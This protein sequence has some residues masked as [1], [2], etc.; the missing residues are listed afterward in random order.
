MIQGGDPL[1]TGKGGV[2]IWGHTFPDEFNKS[3]RFE[4]GGILAMAN[5]G[6]N[7]NTSQFFIT[8]KSAPNLNDKHTIF[9]SISGGKDVLKKLETLETDDNEKPIENVYIIQTIVYYNPFSSEQ[10]EDEKQEKK[11]QEKIENDKQ[12]FG[13]WLSNP[14]PQPIQGGGIGKY[15]NITT[16]KKTTKENLPLVK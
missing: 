15:L 14:S 8:Y 10:I 12:L 4:G 11:E 6:P 1:G 5:Y 16:Q 7:T 2:S 9:G 3:L 13:Q